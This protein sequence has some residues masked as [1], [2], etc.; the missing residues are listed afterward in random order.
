MNK[1]HMLSIGLFLSGGF[2]FFEWTAGWWSHSL[3]LITD[4]GHMLSD[5][6]A[7][8][9]A[10]GAAWLA[11]LAIQKQDSLGPQTAEIAAALANGIGLLVLAVWVVWEAVNRFH[12]EH[13]A[14]AGE[15]MLVTAI[16]GL[17]VNIIAASVL[18]DHSQHD[19]NVRGAFLHVLA[20]TVSSAGVIVSAVLIWAFHWNWVDQ[21]ISLCIAVMLG[22]GSLPLIFDSLQSLQRASTAKH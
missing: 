21:I 1:I 17:G 12:G 8:S 3:T 22:I 13:P 4:A 14:V 9:L 6:L 2:S 15:V 7:L 11:H 16:V 5:C 20:D 18:H 19:F 10:I